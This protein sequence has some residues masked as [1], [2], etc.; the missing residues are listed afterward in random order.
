MTYLIFR[1]YNNYISF[2]IKCFQSKKKSWEMSS[3][4]KYDTHLFCECLT[5]L[6][7][8]FQLET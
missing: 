4:L 3:H 7:L 8:I 2:D 6:I 1:M 5:H